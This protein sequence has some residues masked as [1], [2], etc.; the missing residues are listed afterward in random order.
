M[1]TYT[2][3]D[4]SLGRPTSPLNKYYAT[5]ALMMEETSAPSMLTASCHCGAIRIEVDS[6]PTYFNQCHCSICRRYGTLWAYYRPDEVRLLC[7]PNATEIYCWGD[8][9]I[10]F[11]RCRACG[12]VTHWAPVDKNETKMGVNG[13]LFDE[14]DVAQV[15]VEQDP[16][17]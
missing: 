6:L 15:P 4:S 3:F 9:E 11:H 2:H 5:L 1:S 10:E 7:T 8:K 13:R 14:A 12:C 16:G 17:P